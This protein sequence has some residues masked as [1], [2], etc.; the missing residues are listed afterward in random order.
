M[1]YV[2]IRAKHRHDLLLRLHMR[3]GKVLRQTVDV[4]EV[5]ITLILM[6]LIQLRSVEPLIVKRLAG[7]SVGDWGRC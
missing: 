1:A 2:V 4:V 6:L 7:S 5:S 3:S